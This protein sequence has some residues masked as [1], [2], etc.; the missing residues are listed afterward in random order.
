M[1]QIRIP[2]KEQF[3]GA[4]LSGQKT[5][6]TRTNVYGKTGDQFE[7]FGVTFELVLVVPSIALWVGNFL[8]REEGFEA[9]GEFHLLWDKMHPRLKREAIVFVH[10]FK[11]L[12][13][14]N[15]EGVDGN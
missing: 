4:V 15:K 3:R 14:T 6:T 12:A 10:I 11:R 5:C 8:Y 7:A 2:F 1:K 9:P 13:T